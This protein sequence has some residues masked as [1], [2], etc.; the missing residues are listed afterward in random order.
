MKFVIDHLSKGF[1]KKEVLKEITFIHF[2]SCPG[3]F[4][5]GAGTK[6]AAG[7]RIKKFFLPLRCYTGV[8]ILT[9][10]V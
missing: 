3:W 10:K 6:L 8:R 9:R 5:A 1:G 7:A 2:F 4:R